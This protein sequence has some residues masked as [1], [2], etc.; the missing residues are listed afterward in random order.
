MM[1]W[2]VVSLVVFAS[3]GFA[4]QISMKN[5][6]RLTGSVIKSD[7]KDLVLKS[8][9]AGQVTIPWDAVTAVNST[10]QL[11]VGLKDGQVVVGTVTTLPDGAVQVATR[12]TGMVSTT[13]D[14]IDFLRSNAEQAEAERYLNPRIV[15]LW[16]G[17][18]DLGYAL[19]RGNSKTN[20]FT[21]ST[22]ANRTTSRDKISAYFTQIYASSDT[23]GISQTTANA[24]RGGIAYNLNLT[25]RWFVFGLVDLENDQFQSL[26][27]R[28]APAGGIGYHIVNTERTQFDALIGGSLNREFFTS[29]R[30]R[31]SGEIL[32]AEELT[33]KLNSVTSLHEKLSFFPNMSDTGEYRMNFDTT[34]VTAIRKWFS[35]QFTVSDRYL[36]NPA[37]G[38]KKNDFLFTT[39]LRLSF[40]K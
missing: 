10:E 8:D 34:M 39:G 3:L 35:W 30:N 14:K 12:D 6:D 1:Q 11:H 28:F 36:S 16:T 40:A 32:L 13:R 23:S 37:I 17:T 26:D 19:S 2:R 31:T 24:K 27:L 18:L 5:G 33:H 20:T 25:H 22:T 15:D 7:G 9:L 4:D 38:R 29:G 21:L